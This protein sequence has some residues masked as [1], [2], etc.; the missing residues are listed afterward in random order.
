MAAAEAGMTQ[1]VVLHV[2]ALGRQRGEDA[3]LELVRKIRARRRTR[4]VE[5]AEGLERFAGHDE[6]ATRSASRFT[7]TVPAM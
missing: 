5:G 6:S 2:G 7:T 4:A 1:R 3:A